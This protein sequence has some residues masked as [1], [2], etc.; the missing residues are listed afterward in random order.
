MSRTRTRRLSS[1]THRSTATAFGGWGEVVL[2][3]K[4]TLILDSETDVYLYKDSDTQ[5]KVGV[6][7]KAG[8]FALDTSASGD[9]TQL[10]FRRP[11]SRSGQP[12]LSRRDRTLG[13]LHPQTP[14]LR[15]KF[16]AIP[17]SP[18]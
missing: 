13:V 18:W 16:A 8:G 9:Y 5:S 10:R 14:I 4:S 17:K 6:T 1:P 12:R 7:K 15:I 11:P 2:G 3:S